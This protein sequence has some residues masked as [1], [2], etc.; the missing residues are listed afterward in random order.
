M[1]VIVLEELPSVIFC[2]Y[3]NALGCR[4]RI[5]QVVAGAANAFGTKE[6]IFSKFGKQT[7]PA[8]DKYVDE[9]LVSI[10]ELKHPQLRDVTWRQ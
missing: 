1:S 8:T 5:H 7:D 6:V 10:T 9:F 2:Y 4:A 3:A